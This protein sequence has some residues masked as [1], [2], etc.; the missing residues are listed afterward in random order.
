M[1]AT[2][3]RWNHNFHYHPLL[4]A[5][6]RPGAQLAL[7][8]GCGDGELAREL[9]AQVAHVTGIDADA[10]SIARARALSG[11]LDNLHFVAGDFLAHAFAAESF[12]AVVSVAAL[13]HMP[14]EPALEAMKQLLR[15]GGLLGIVG[16][17]RSSTP[18]DLACD[19]A[20]VL[21]HRIHSA[22]RGYRQQT[23]PVADPALSYLQVRRATAAIL[24]GR[25]FLRH[26]LFRYSILWTKP[27]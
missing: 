14:L 18:C 9:A 2:P 17:A 22:R 23:A 25:R 7:D 8:V 26:V 27:N 15:P 20:G 6:L 4:L 13:H 12:D 19:A 10:E 21:V 11:G 24:P 3:G 5:A 16:L 1:C